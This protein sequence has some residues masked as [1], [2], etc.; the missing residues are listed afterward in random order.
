[1]PPF[2]GFGT[3][4]LPPGKFGAILNF[5]FA[6]VMRNLFQAYCLNL[7]NRA[8]TQ[9]LTVSDVDAYIEFARTKTRCS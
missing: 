6:L 8:M 7:H 9:S 5:R 4:V 1:M 3:P 2:W